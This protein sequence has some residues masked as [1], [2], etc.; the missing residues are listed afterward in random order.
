MSNTRRWMP[1]SRC[2]KH[3]A[4]SK[5]AKFIDQDSLEQPARH[6]RGLIVTRWTPILLS[7]ICL[8][9]FVIRVVCRSYMGSADFWQNGYYFFYEI[10]KNIVDG[11]DLLLPGPHGPLYPYFLALTALPGGHYMFTVI[12][13]ALFGVVTVACAFLTRQRTLWR[14][15]RAYRSLLDCLLPLLRDS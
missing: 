8:A 9:A 4:M 12:P 15:S 2:Y 11:G 1:T 10:A 6:A 14:T 13:Q 7:V 5:L 3:L